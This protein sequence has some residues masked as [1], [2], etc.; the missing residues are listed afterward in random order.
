[1]STTYSQLFDLAVNPATVLRK[2]ISVAVFKSATDITNAANPIPAQL[3]WARGVLENPSA[4]KSIADQS[5]W[6]VLQNASVF[7]SLTTTP[8]T[9]TDSDVQFVVNSLLPQLARVRI[10]AGGN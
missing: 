2:Q 9:V 6:L 3:L 5:V 4:P 7:T 1:M 8:F 10:P